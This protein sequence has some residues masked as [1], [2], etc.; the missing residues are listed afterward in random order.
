M[1]PFCFRLRDDIRCQ[2]KAKRCFFCI[3]LRSVYH[4]CNIQHAYCTSHFFLITCS[5]RCTTLPTRHGRRSASH[6]RWIYFTYLSGEEERGSVQ[7][8]FCKGG[9]NKKPG[10]R[11]DEAFVRHI[12]SR[13]VRFLSV[14]S[15]AYWSER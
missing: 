4:H 1:I 9:K 10:R 14:E 12:Q 7:E 5:S 13:A 3:Y 2:L 8:T 6:F 15:A 11:L